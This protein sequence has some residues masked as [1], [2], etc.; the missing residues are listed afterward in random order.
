MTPSDLHRPDGGLYDAVLVHIDRA[1]D[2]MLATVQGL[3][4]ELVNAPTGLPDGN[5]A[6]QLVRHCCGVLESWGGRVLANPADSA[7]PLGG[8]RVDRVGCR[9]DWP[10]SGA[11]G[12]LRRGS[13]P[14]QRSSRPAGSATRARSGPWR[15]AHAGRHPAARLR[16]TR[17]TPRPPRHHSGCGAL[18]I[19]LPDVRRIVHTAARFCGHPRLHLAVSTEREAP[20]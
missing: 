7:G 18:S 6:F 17:P 12:P 1:L 8:V 15:A 9:T 10:R 20:A 5:T 11:P 19:S 14:F 13:A 4:D 3:G 16:R 2:G